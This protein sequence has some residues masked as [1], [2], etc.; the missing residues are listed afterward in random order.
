MAEPILNKSMEK[1]QSESYLSITSNDIKINLS[2]E[3]LEELQKNTYHGW[4]DE[5]VIDHIA[6]VLEI[7][8]L[9]RVPGTDSHQLRMKIFPLSLT[10]EARQWWI[11]EGEGKITVW[12]E[13]VEKFFCKF[14]PDSY[15]GEDEMLD[16]GDNW[17]ID[18]LEFLS[19]VNSSFD[20]HMKI[21]GR[22]KKVLFHAWMNGNWNKRRIDNS[23]LSSNNT[24][25]DSFFIPNL[26]THKKSN[27]KKKEEQSQTK[28]KYNNTSSTT[29]EQPNKRRCKAEKFEAIQYSLGPNEE[30]IAIRSYEY[31]IWERNE[32]NLSIIYVKI[33]NS[34]LLYFVPCVMIDHYVAFSSFRHCRGVTEEVHEIREAL[35]EQRKVMDVMARDLSRFTV[36]AVGG[37]SQLLDSAGAT[38]IRYSE[39]HVPYQR[40][41]V[42]QRTDGAST[43][44]AQQDEQQPDP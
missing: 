39:T 35:G 7:V 19:R 22:T 38:Y 8:D 43:F 27:T 1:A 24:T 13:L 37:I 3:F 21:D 28:R 40:C 9:I 20:K 15:D 23:I 6:K 18:P 17:G 34:S 25:S 14:Y 16:E 29:D 12:E 10:D 42:R 5:D 36:W 31:D 44:T 2:K 33:K 11:D 41:R 30:Y 4:I 26:K 32:D